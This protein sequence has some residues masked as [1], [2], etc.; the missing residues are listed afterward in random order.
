MAY[1]VLDAAASRFP[2]YR[3]PA[4]SVLERD[5]LGADLRATLA[6]LA[7]WPAER[8]PA[9]PAYQ[10]L[11][12][13]WQDIHR[14][15]LHNLGVV[16]RSLRRL[17]ED[18]LDGDER[19]RLAGEIMPASMHAVEHLHAHHRLEDQGMFPQLLRAAPSLARP[20]NLLEADHIV[21]NALLGPFEHALARLPGADAP[22]SAWDSVASA[23]ERVARVARRHIADEEEIVIPAVLGEAR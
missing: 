1:T 4:H 2:D 14:A 16:E 5:G 8:W 11:A 17:A 3:A 19:V 6:G 10:G 23:G 18:R 12:S 13:H 9:H 7:A 20:L 15:M 22:A 21:L